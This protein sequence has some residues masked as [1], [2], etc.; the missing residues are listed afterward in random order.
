VKIAIETGK[1][2]N[3]GYDIVNHCVDDILVQGARPLF[4]MDYY[5]TGVLEEEVLKGVVL[6]LSEACRENNCALLGGETAE[7]PGFYHEG[8]FDLAGAIVGAVDKSLIIDGNGIRSGDIVLGLA[9]SGLHTNGFSLARK[10]LFETA[11]FKLNDVPDGLEKSVGMELVEPHKSYFQGLYPLVQ[12]KLIKGMAHITG[13]GFQGNIP[14]ILPPGISVKINRD[15]WQVPAIFN[16]IQFHGEVEKEEMYRTFNMGV[17]MVIIVDKEN[18]DRIQ[19]RLESAG[20]KVFYI[21]EAM[22]SEGTSEVVF[23]N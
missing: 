9:S 6:G 18:A 11:G 21:G 5:A 20:E 15:A 12:E 14:R 16:L 1:Y 22:D 3:P 13:G 4:F 7:M 19:S 2:A 8:D 17:G 23:R 10:V